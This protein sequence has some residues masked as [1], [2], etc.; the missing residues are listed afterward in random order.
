MIFVEWNP[1]IFLIFVLEVKFLMW[2]Y[3]TIHGIAFIV[4]TCYTHILKDIGNTSQVVLWKNSFKFGI[5]G[6]FT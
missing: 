3:F 1:N 4:Y 6:F 5:E 2:L